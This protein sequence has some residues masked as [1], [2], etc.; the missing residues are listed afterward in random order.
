MRYYYR[1]HLA[2]YD[3]VKREGKRTWH[4]M[5]P[6]AFENFSS[7]KVLEGI[8][9]RLQFSVDQP[10]VLEYGCGTG[11]G[12][13][14]LAQRGFLVDGLDLIPTAIEIARTNASELGVDI[15][16]G[17]QDMCELSHVGK[18]YDLIVDSFCLQSF[19]PPVVSKSC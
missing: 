14:F 10:E 15:S 4:E 6:D 8:L 16:F 5:K 19:V 7:R 13:C 1:E 11:P 18:Q 12:A 9:P 17:V 3:W 2:G